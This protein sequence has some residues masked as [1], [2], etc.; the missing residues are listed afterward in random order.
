MAF[1]VHYNAG[2]GLGGATLELPPHRR[3]RVSFLKVG[4][5]PTGVPTFAGLQI[6]I[7]AQA[8]LCLQSFVV[9]RFVPARL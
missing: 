5:L 3:Q 1:G 2:F 4:A 9:G 8:K 6:D 7:P